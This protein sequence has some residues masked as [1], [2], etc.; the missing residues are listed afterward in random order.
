MVKFKFNQD[1][2]NNNKNSVVVMHLTTAQALVMHEVGEIVGKVK[3]VKE[4][5]KKK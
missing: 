4:S 3:M 1:H 2:G 5:E